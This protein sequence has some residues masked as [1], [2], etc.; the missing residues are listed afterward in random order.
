MTEAGRYII[1]WISQG[2]VGADTD[3]MFQFCLPQAHLYRGFLLFVFTYDTCCDSN[4]Q[5][6]G[7]GHS[8]K[9]HAFAFS[10]ISKQAVASEIAFAFTK[11]LYSCCIIQGNGYNTHYLVFTFIVRSI[12]HICVHLHLI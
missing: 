3:L 11:Y 12:T 10:C 2:D 7:L 9:L 4:N 8:L 1:L 6:R 5:T